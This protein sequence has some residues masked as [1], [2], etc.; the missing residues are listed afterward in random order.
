M[1]YMAPARA[2]IMEKITYL[3]L[4]D[5]LDVLLL[6]LT[7]EHA[8]LEETHVGDKVNASFLVVTK[9]SE[10]S[11]TMNCGKADDSGIEVC[12]CILA[13]LHYL[14]PRGNDPQALHSFAIGVRD[15]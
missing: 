14:L 7:V 10:R 3:R 12:F 15:L 1:R 8:S 6:M 2:L 5:E 13:A 11:A 4:D 9:L